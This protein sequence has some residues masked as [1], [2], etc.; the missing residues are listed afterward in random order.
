MARDGVKVRPFGRRRGLDT[1]SL[2]M[3]GR[4]QADGER[5][6]RSNL[7]LKDVVFVKRSHAALADVSCL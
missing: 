6:A 1:V 5:M 3:S 2:A 4:N 7:R